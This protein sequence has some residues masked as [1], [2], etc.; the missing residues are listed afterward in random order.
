V[1]RGSPYY[2]SPEQVQGRELDARSDQYA[3]GVVCYEMLTGRKPFTGLT[4]MDLMQQH[5]SGER[6]PLPPELAAYEPL[7]GRLM[8][9]EREARFPNMDAVLADLTELAAPPAARNADAA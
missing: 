2:M 6:P 9:R 3:L 1:L 7:V 5:V 8:A 4:A